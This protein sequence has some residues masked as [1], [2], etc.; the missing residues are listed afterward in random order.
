MGAMFKPFM[1]KH[2]IED[3]D[4]FRKTMKVDEIIAKHDQQIHLTSEIT[5]INKEIE[6]IQA[7]KTREKLEEAE[8]ELKQIKS[9]DRKNELQKSLKS[10]ETLL[11]LKKKEFSLLK[12]D[13]NVAY[14]PIHN[15][16][17]LVL[18]VGVLRERLPIIL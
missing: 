16:S 15:L 7:R 1:K 5:R 18:E 14:V 3:L 17:K 11:E 9:N 12:A 2:H 13:M 8:H 10:K 6:K 4:E